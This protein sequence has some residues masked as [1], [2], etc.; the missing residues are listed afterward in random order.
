[1]ICTNC[2]HITRV[3]LGHFEEYSTLLFP[4]NLQWVY[5]FVIE[6]LHPITAGAFTSKKYETSEMAKSTVFISYCFITDDLCVFRSYECA[7]V[8]DK[9]MLSV[10]LHVDSGDR[11][12]LPR[13]AVNTAMKQ[14]HSGASVF[15]Y[16]QNSTHTHWNWSMLPSFDQNIIFAVH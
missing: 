3:C 4:C 16:K 14:S 1:M 10:A 12:G 11:N 7:V 13:Q 6:N 2:K 9:W 8:I 5:L 15:V